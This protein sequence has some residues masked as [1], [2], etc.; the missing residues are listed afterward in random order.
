MPTFNPLQMAQ[1]QLA[2]SAE[3]LGLPEPIRMK[4]AHP[5]RIVIVAVPAR[6]D[7][8]SLQVYTGYRVQHSMERG[9]CK[10]GIRY[11]PVVDLDEMIALAMWMTWKAAV[12][13]IPYGGA[14]GGV[15]CDPH[16]LSRAE[17]ERVTRRF[18]SEL[19]EVIGPE[20][21]I[22]APDVGTDEEVMAWMMDTYSMNRGYVVPGVVTGKP[23]AVGGSRGRSEAT[24]RG[25]VCIMEEALSARGKLREGLT[26]AIQGF[27]KVGKATAVLAA[28][29]GFR[30]I[31]V[32]DVHG[33]VRNPQGLDMLSLEAHAHE[34]GVIHTFPD[35]EEI[36]R[37]ELLALPCDVLVPAALEGALT[38][39]N[40]G[41]VQARMI[42]EAAN[43]P[44]TPEAQ[45][46]FRE[47]GIPVVP[48]ILA[49]AGGVTISYFEWVQDLQAYFWT[50]EDVNQKLYQI[51]TQAFRDV[52]QVAE[53][54]KLDLREA[55]L[56]LAIGRV[57][58]A[59]ALRGIYP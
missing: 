22:P 3:R 12:V 36:A 8:G 53:E 39:D 6:M 2:E 41:A 51:M 24:G 28:Q 17:L 34:H 35:G 42:V 15:N 18:T 11:H 45:A 29:A 9:P 27:G 46:I 25:C 50:E 47:R 5:K 32:S 59:Q 4:L 52:S 26:V 43:G 58:E 19:V 54:R 31:A 23:L 56:D 44:T 40:A 7:D 16:S 57:A 33:A 14:K 13:N 55:A 30:V 21:D 38:A 37:E 48:D 20:K 49:N 10:G 1:S